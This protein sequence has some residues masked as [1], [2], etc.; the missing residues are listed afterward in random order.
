MTYDVEDG[1]VGVAGV[2]VLR[3]V[4]NKSFLVRKSDPGRR[5]TVTY[6]GQ[7]AH[8]PQIIMPSAA[9]EL[10]LIV[11]EDFH[12]SV[13]HHTHTRVGCAQINTDNRSSNCLLIVLQRLL[14]VGPRRREEEGAT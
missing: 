9:V 7:L 6:N 8:V 5:Y 4:T 14:I 12:A 2:L 3:R 1:P 10:T 13:L 11:G